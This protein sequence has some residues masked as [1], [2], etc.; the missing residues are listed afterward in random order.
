MDEILLCYFFTVFL[1]ANY[2]LYCLDSKINGWIYYQTISFQTYEMGIKDAYTLSS[3]GRY[4]ANNS[5]DNINT[6]I[7]NSSRL[8]TTAVCVGVLLLAYYM[9]CHVYY[10]YCKLRPVKVCIYVHCEI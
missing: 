3:R 1:N 2:D 10:M 9:E 4:V 7:F 8:V 5:P 6:V